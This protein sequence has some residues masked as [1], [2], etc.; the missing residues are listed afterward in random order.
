[1]SWLGL[2]IW[3]ELYT[4]FYTEVIC[5]YQHLRQALS[6]YISPAFLK[7]VKDTNS[8]SSFCVVFRI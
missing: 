5:L 2:F 1:M 7:I 3:F 6:G 8:I 4:V